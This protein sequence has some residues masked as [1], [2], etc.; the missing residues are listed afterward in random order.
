MEINISLHVPQDKTDLNIGISKG[1]LT[2][3][4]INGWIEISIGDGDLI[5][6]SMQGYFSAET[7]SGDLSVELSGRRW[8]GHGFT[9]MT[10]RGSVELRL[11]LD[12][13]AALQLETHM[14]DLTIDYP[15]Q[16]VDGQ[17]VPLHII[18]RKNVRNLTATV[19]QGG[20][21]VK[22]FTSVG[23][24]MLGKSEIPR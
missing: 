6:R 1:D 13:S 15:E 8:N 2:I 11:P 18:T 19:G 16:V 20:A 23:D 24:I 22:L 14:G 12:Y 10:R 3:G 7:E 4:N 17:Y 21:P 5:A 9:A